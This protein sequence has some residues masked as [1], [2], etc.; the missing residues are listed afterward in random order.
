MFILVNPYT[1]VLIKISKTC[2]C[3]INNKG[4]NIECEEEKATAY[5]LDDGLV[6]PK[7]LPVEMHEIDYIPEGVIPKILP[8]EI[9]GMDNGELKEEKQ[10][11]KDFSN[12]VRTS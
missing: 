12:F 8:W 2:S 5:L 1:Y 9:V 3:I 6:Y 4:E 7:S 11:L 10:L